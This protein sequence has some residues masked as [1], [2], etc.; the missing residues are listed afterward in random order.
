[1]RCKT[2][3]GIAAL[4]ASG[5]ALP[6]RAEAASYGICFK[7]SIGLNDSGFEMMQGDGVSRD[8]DYYPWQ[9]PHSVVSR[10]MLVE[11]FDNGDKIG[12]TVN[13]GTDG[14]FTLNTSQTPPFVARV[15]AR[16]ESSDDNVIRVVNAQPPAA[17]LTM[18]GDFAINPSA[19]NTT[20]FEVGGNTWWSTMAAVSAFAEYR[21]DWENGGEEFRISVCST[22]NCSSSTAQP[23]DYEDHLARIQISQGCGSE[24]D[25]RRSKFTI[26]HEMGHTWWRVKADEYEP[27]RTCT[28]WPSSSCGSG[29]YGMSTTEWSV[30]GAKEG[31]ADFY[32]VSVWNNTS[33]STAVYR[34]NGTSY[35]V[36]Y[37]P[38]GV[39][40]DSGG[41][42]AQNG[43]GPDGL[44]VR[45][46]WM[47]TLWDW[48]TPYG[49]G[50]PPGYAIADVWALMIT[51]HYDDTYELEMDTY[52][53]GILRAVSIL[54]PA[55]ED[56]FAYYAGY[57][58][59]AT[60]DYP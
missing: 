54:C 22:C 23:S 52:Y 31:V 16:A 48:H 17:E 40:N 8:E 3:L 11:I 13:V 7:W 27:F 49:A 37:G 59:T 42:L 29:S 30:I 57:N 9:L 44:G 10:N 28:G 24:S 21:E 6:G 15:Y 60:S 35:D 25:K 36:E 1:M 45:E 33:A 41:Q 46:D 26:A 56:D 51:D 34:R 32:S 14:C 2:A 58:G 5:L 55:Y 47:R 18:S 53:A 19:G 12:S 43:D 4:A 20:T 38:P 39:D 50:K